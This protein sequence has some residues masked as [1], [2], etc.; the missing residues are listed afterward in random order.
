MEML[1]QLCL[2]QQL[3]V[4]RSDLDRS[5]R[6]GLGFHRCITL[7]SFPCIFTR[8]QAEL[9]ASMSRERYLGVCTSSVVSKLWQAVAKIILAAWCYDDTG[10]FMK[11]A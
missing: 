8:L 6:A 5:L 2:S 9:Q 10:P 1:V 11:M 4:R 7:F 3:V